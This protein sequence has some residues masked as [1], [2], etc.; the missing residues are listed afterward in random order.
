M[1]LSVVFNLSFAGKDPDKNHPED[2]AADTP[3]AEAPHTRPS[4]ISF[5]ASGLHGGL[6]SKGLLTNVCL[7]EATQHWTSRNGR[8]EQQGD[9]RAGMEDACMHLGRPFCPCPLGGTSPR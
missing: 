4:P 9:V 6:Q 2:E 1:L 7:V 5:A 8:K 3:S